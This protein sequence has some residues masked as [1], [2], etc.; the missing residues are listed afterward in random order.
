MSKKN[1]NVPAAE[2]ENEAVKQPK[3]KK[4]KGSAFGRFLRRFFL[5]IF[6]TF[7]YKMR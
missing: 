7:L 4:K 1:K 6:V 3:K 5:L 2:Q